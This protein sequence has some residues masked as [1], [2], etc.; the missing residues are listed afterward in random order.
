MVSTASTRFNS[1]VKVK[2]FKPSMNTCNV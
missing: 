2:K 1:H